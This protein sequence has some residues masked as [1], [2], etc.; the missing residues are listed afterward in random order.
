MQWDF[1]GGKENVNSSYKVLRHGSNGR[2]LDIIRGSNIRSEGSSC[3]VTYEFILF[4]TDIGVEGG[5]ISIARIHVVH[6]L[7]R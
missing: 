6:S 2:A 7:S 3:D 4:I 5:G 1:V